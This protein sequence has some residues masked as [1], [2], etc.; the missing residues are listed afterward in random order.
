VL[1]PPVM[2][3]GAALHD[4][5][6]RC[7]PLDLNA[8]YAYF[9]ICAHFSA[10]SVVAADGDDPPI[11]YISAYLKPDDPET[12]FVWQVAVDPDARGRGLASAMLNKLFERP[13]T[14]GV[15][16]LETTVT[17]SNGGSLRMFE[18]FAARR[19]A[20]C[21][22]TVF[23]EADQFRSNGHEREELLRI[24]PIPISEGIIK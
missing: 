6:R 17:P 21:Q 23:I 9:L 10:T 13:A 18:K 20:P 16:F 24:G 2:A 22:S 11:G 8:E 19:G 14:R 5:V 4:L 3:D 1:R 15:R 12:L 7:P